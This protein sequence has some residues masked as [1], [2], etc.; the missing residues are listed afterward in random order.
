MLI[1][2]GEQSLLLLQHR[3]PLCLHLLWSVGLFFLAVNAGRSA[4]I[5]ADK[6]WKTCR[7]VPPAETRYKEVQLR[8]PLLLSIKAICVTSKWHFN[9]NFRQVI[10]NSFLKDAEGWAVVNCNCLELGVGGGSGGLKGVWN[11]RQIDEVEMVIQCVTAESD[12]PVPPMKQLSW[13]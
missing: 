9:E 3:Q 8:S 4:F 11:A 6:R 12:K 13:H 7:P 5:S 10:Q 2:A 1:N